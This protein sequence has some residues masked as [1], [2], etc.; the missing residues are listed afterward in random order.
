M[1]LEHGFRGCWSFPVET[2]SGALVGS[3]AMYWK[4]PREPGARELEL[5]ATLRQSAGVIISRG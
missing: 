5:A 1:A 2:V 3:L 4:E